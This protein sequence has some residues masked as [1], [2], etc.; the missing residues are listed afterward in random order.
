MTFLQLQN[1][2]VSWL[3]DKNFGYFTQTEVQMWLNNGQREVQKMLL[4]AG[5]NWYVKCVE[6]TLVVNQ[7]DYVLPDDFLKLHR[8]EVVISGT[9]PNEEVQVLEQITLNQQDLFPNGASTP[10]GYYLKKERIILVPAPDTALIMRMQYSP[11]V[12]DMTDSAE[13]PDVPVQYHE[14]LAVLATLDGLYKDTRDPGPMLQKKQYYE[15]LM[16]QDAQN[17]RQDA[18]RSV[19]VTTSYGFE[20]LY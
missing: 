8:L 12:A 7:T 11:L 4:Q 20:T 13:E 9:A 3:D 16:K 6:T 15:T 2:V 5:E 1:L 14:M 19:V 18:P 10:A 17:R